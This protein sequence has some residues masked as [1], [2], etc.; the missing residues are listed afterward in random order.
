MKMDKPRTAVARRPL[1]ELEQHRGFV[2]WLRVRV[3]IT[4]G[5]EGGANDVLDKSGCSDC[6]RSSAVF[7]QSKHVEIGCG[8]CENTNRNLYGI[9]VGAGK[10]EWLL[11]NNLYLGQQ[12]R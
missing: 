8:G 6:A 10:I 5:L 4:E 1:A 9:R 11:K 2:E 12:L 3:V 7:L